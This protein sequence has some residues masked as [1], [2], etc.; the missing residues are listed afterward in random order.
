MHLQ[1]PFSLLLTLSGL[2]CSSS[3]LPF[4]QWGSAPSVSIVARAT[5]SVVPIDGSGGEDGGYSTSNEP[6]VTV[7]ETQTLISTQTPTIKTITESSPP[8][9]STLTVTA[10]PTTYTYAVPT[11]ISIIDI[12]PTTTVTTT[13]V[14]GDGEPTSVVPTSSGSGPTSSTLT[15]SS[16]LSSVVTPIQTSQATTSLPLS[17]NI[18]SYY[19][20]PTG[21]SVETSIT[22]SASLIS[23]A[24]GDGHWHT[25]CPS[26]NETTIGRSIRGQ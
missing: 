9:T 6:P 1:P 14:I 25:T 8:I 10:D 24:F 18:T 20:T 4:L 21:G 22:A 11:T 2:Y 12:E 23:E 15:S 19:V 3:A 26:W 17:T 16:T 7:I 5:W 13:T